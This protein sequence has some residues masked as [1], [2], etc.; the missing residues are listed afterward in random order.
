MLICLPSID[1]G[2]VLK[3][4]KELGEVRFE[5]MPNHPFSPF[6]QHKSLGIAMD[7]SG[8]V[9]YGLGCQIWCK[10]VFDK[11]FEAH[12]NRQRIVRALSLYRTDCRIRRPSP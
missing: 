4:W 3:G 2:K 9:L 11:Q 8:K 6:Y 5:K 10:F 12:R 7:L 1:G